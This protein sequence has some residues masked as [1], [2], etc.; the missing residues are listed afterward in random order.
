MASKVDWEKGEQLYRPGLLSNA[1]I[2]R[3]IGCSDVAV[4]KHAKKFGWKRDLKG[5]VL[6]EVREKLV[7]AA[8]REMA[9]A[10]PA[11]EL[12]IVEAASEESAAV[13]LHH[14]KDIRK[15]RNI[16]R[17][18]FEQLTHAAVYR[19][20]IETA[21]DEEIR[22]AE[23]QAAAETHGV[24]TANDAQRL[25][26]RKRRMQDAISLQAHAAIA[27][28]LSMSMKHLIGCERDAFGLNDGEF[29][30]PPSDAPAVAYDVSFGG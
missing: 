2:G 6:H 28:D 30:K 1:E 9:N 7:R 29:G 8:V 21:I 26:A 19:D 10:N 5:K 24:I 15:G 23:T 11:T 20:E 27:R 3:R 13:V 14:R 18:L 22:N 17:T 4:A 25:K 12:Q 16:V